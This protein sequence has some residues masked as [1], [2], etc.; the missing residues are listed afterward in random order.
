MG[1]K[2]PSHTTQTT[3]VE[4][5]AWV[6]KA[7]QENY[8]FAKEISSKPLVQYGG[9]MVADKSKN[10]LLAEQL[11]KS[12]LGKGE[13]AYNSAAD[14]FKNLA[15]LDTTITPQQI[16]SQNTTAGTVNAGTTTA[17]Q[18]TSRD[19][20]AGTTTSRDTTAAQ[21]TPEMLRDMD[22]GAYLN[23]YIDN[24]ESHSLAALEDSRRQAL[25]GNAARATSA[26]AFGGSRSAI[27]D[28]VTNAESAKDAG[29]L[30]AQ[31][32]QAGY[33]RATELA[34]G[35]IT[36]KMAADTGN[37]D[38][39]LTSDT[40]NANRALQSDQANRDAALASDQANA[41]RAL[42]SDTANADRT[43]TSDT[44]NVNRILEALMSNRD[45]ALA[46][47]TN[48]ANRNLTAQQ[49]NQA[50]DLDAQSTSL[51]ARIQAMLGGAQGNL[52][53][54]EGAQGARMQDYTGLAQ[55]GLA[56]QQRSQQEIN[57]EMAK[58]AERQGYDA[59]MLNMRLAAL[60][61]SPYGKTETAQKETSGGGGVDWAS[62]GLGIFSMLL[63]LSDDD[64]KTD[65][66]KV[67]KVPG[68][69]LDLWAFRY[70]DDPKSYPKS[71]GVMAS[72]VEKKMPAAVH[73]TSD[74]TRV[75]NYGMLAEHL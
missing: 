10:S 39:S 24:V 49:N 12:N 69:D 32:R 51:Q 2:Q 11:F 5:P 9:D 26:G 22:L 46:S 20:T 18:T 62:T 15:G 33:D 34:T 38:R 71:I 56:D 75:I 13:A 8:D 45:A 3:K 36:R 73:K 65:K 48:N 68:S 67:G 59:E 31:L 72:D 43:L 17:G 35:D 21:V 28:A 25:T 52:A 74:G 16:T 6:D 66:K 27:V 23:P 63:G 4:L 44:N 47:D 53:A 54:A 37:A 29:L 64:T 42:Q 55:M 60:G 57:A 58:F 30:S 40:N 50:A 14:M 19:T 1:S 41:N 70:K 61:M 7:S